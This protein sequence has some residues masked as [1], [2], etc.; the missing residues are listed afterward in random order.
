M[1]GDYIVFGRPC[2]DWIGTGPRVAEFERQ[3]AEY[4]GCRHAVALGSCSA[5]LHLA[6]GGLGLA[7]GSEII[8]TPLAFVATAHAIIHAG[9]RPVFA[10]VDPASMNLS[11]D[12]IRRRITPRTRAILP[13][14]LAGRPC[15]MDLILEI[16]REHDLF[17]IE[18][19]AHAVEAWYHRRRVGALG[20]VGCFSFYVTKNMTTVEGGMLCSDHHEVAGR[21]RT[22]ALQGM[23]ADAWARS[24]DDGYRHYDVVAP[25][26]K[27]NMTDVQAAIGLC[28]LRKQKQWHE[29]RCRLWAFYDR[30]FAD[31][32]CSRPAPEAPETVHARHLYTLQID[33][34]RCGID[35]DRF[36]AELHRRRIGTGVHSRAI[37]P[38]TYYREALGLRPEEAPNAHRIGETTVSLPFGVSLTDG[39]AAR[40]VAA[41]REVLGGTGRAR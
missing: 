32:P 3:F 29:R 33:P 34:E 4:L 14:H 25:G 31:L 40:V 13:V 8:T 12:E 39:D 18:D 17:V 26:Y 16:A 23:T 11:P 5:A 21:A 30:E 9:A 28:Q 35:R 24:A 15:E 2:I 36:M 27:Y 1:D 38:L 19:A 37:H 41:V 20:D 7:P 10:D 6:L 22:L